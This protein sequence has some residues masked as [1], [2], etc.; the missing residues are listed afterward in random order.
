MPCNTSISRRPPRLAARGLVRL[1]TLRL[2]GE[3][4]AVQYNL[5]RDRRVYYYLSGF[6]PAHARSSPAPRCLLFRFASAIE[7][8]ATQFDF[9]RKREEFKYHWGARDAVNRRLLVT[10]SAV[11]RA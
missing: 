5:R 1:Y 11:V 6:D 2:N 10:H 9:L 7:E 4:I 8:G 3:T